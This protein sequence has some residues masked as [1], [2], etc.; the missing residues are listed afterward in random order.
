[1]TDLEAASAEVPF[2]EGSLES[3]Q[4]QQAVE[5]MKS[6]QNLLAGVAGGAVGAL[7]GAAIWA[8]VTVVTGYQI[9]WMAVG[10]GFLAGFGVRLL[11]KG[12]DSVFGAAGAALALAG[13]GLGNV[14][15]VCGFISQNESMPFLEV[16]SR[17]DLG[18]TWEL[19]AATFSPMDLLFYGIA[20]YEGYKFSFRRVTREELGLPAAAEG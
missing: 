6:E 1:M 18:V 14:L 5:K 17:L 10:V 15:A 8:V 12:L 19:L 13:C 3:L 2:E 4:L 7:L 9:G 16:V 20:V 11:G